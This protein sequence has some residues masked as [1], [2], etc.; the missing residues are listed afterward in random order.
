MT[1]LFGRQG[2]FARAAQRKRQRP[3][4]GLVILVD[5]MRDFVPEGVQDFVPAMIQIRGPRQN[6]KATGGPVIAAV[7][8]AGG[9]FNLSQNQT[10]AKM[11]PVYAVK[12]G[13]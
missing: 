7:L 2:V 12:F 4:W 13:P 3:K 8:L 5:N 1:T 9:E 6:D 10:A 11:R